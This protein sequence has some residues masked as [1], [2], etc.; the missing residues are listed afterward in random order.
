MN[1]ILYYILKALHTGEER[2][3]LD[4]GKLLNLTQP[5]LPCLWKC[6]T[7]SRMAVR[8]IHVVVSSAH[9][10]ISH[11]HLS[12]TINVTYTLS[13]LKAMLSLS[14]CF[15]LKFSMKHMSKHII[16]VQLDEFS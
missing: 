15:Y 12:L 11:S 7:L 4:V 6:Y 16:N 9:T 3:D 14:N 13:V 1:Q 10:Q 5:Q 2:R 8:K